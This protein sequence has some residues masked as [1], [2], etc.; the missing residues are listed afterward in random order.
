MPKSLYQIVQANML[1]RNDTLYY[2]TNV[3]LCR[4]S[5]VLS[6]SASSPGTKNVGHQS[7]SS[8]FCAGQVVY[9]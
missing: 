3:S 2:M 7:V 9:T 8:L 4:P 5:V 1:G 6:W